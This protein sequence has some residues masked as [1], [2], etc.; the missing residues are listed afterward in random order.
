VRKLLAAIS[1]RDETGEASQ[2]LGAFGKWQ[3]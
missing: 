3:A 1:V 2:L